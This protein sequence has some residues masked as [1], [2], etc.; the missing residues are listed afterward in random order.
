MSRYFK[1][2]S[3]EIAE[4]ILLTNNVSQVEAKLIACGN[5]VTSPARATPC[6]H[7]FQ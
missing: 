5:T 1:R 7:S 6:K 4:A 3:V 2:A